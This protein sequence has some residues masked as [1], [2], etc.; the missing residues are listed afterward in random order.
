M[1]SLGDP[2]RDARN[3]VMDAIN[4]RY[5]EVALTPAHLTGRSSVPNVISPAWKP[6]GHRQTI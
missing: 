6:F 2:R 5:G 1:F 4:N 3:R